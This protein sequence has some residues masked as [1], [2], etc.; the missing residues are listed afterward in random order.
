MSTIFAIDENNGFLITDHQATLLTGIDAVVVNCQHV[1]LTQRGEN[2]YNVDEGLPNFE[3]VWNGN[4]DLIQFEFFLRQDLSL[5]QDVDSL[6]NFEGQVING[7]VDY[8]IQI[9]TA[10]G[11]TSLNGDT[12]T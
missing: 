10:F 9:N 11:S 7:E 5:V 8:D 2:I 4:P 12:E 3:T 6:S 1:A